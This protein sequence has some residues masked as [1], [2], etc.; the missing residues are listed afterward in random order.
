M[1]SIFEK[2]RIPSERKLAKKTIENSLLENSNR[3]YSRVPSIRRCPS[4]IQILRRVPVYFSILPE[5]ACLFG[6]ALLF[7]KVRQIEG[8]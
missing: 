5:S 6:D 3:I 7:G 1:S 4:I 2:M 8:I